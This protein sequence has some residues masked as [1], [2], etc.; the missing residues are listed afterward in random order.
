MEALG[1]ESVGVL[2][3]G[4]HPLLAYGTIPV[5]TALELGREL[6]RR[7]PEADCLHFA[8]AHWPVA[9]AIEPLEQE[10]GLP[11]MTSGQAIIWKALR[12][13]GLDDRIEGFGRLLREL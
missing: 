3:A 10:L 6:R 8:N 12:T 4:P 13:A 9:F 1:V 5:A 11:V 2:S 7:F